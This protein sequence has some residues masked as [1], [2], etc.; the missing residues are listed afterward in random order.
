MKHFLTQYTEND[1]AY[2][3]AW[4]QINLFGRGICFWRK[5]IQLK[6]LPVSE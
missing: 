1:I 4:L 2:A 3:E 6:K 5:R